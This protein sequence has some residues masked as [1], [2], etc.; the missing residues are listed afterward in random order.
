MEAL[1]ASQESVSIP[2]HDRLSHSCPPRR[3]LS[4]LGIGRESTCTSVKTKRIERLHWR[5]QTSLAKRHRA[6]HSPPPRRRKPIDGNSIQ[7]AALSRPRMETFFSI[8]GTPCT[9][10]PTLPWNRWRSK[11]PHRR[12]MR[13]HVEVRA[14]EN[15][16]PNVSIFVGDCRN[17]PTSSSGD[18]HRPH[19]TTS[20][21]SGKTGTN[22]HNHS[23]PRTRRVVDSQPTVLRTRNFHRHH[24]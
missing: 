14:T 24:S 20:S 22:E 23:V 2:I 15:L 9:H 1:S 16:I 3:R 19:G 17:H 18:V 5:L 13:F 21:T 12:S 4:C 11:S 8:Q 10:G 7:I 6:Q